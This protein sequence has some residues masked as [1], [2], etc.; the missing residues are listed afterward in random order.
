MTQNTKLRSRDHTVYFGTKPLPV[1][2]V[3]LFCFIFKSSDHK[4]MLEIYW[5]NPSSLLKYKKEYG[6]RYH[7]SSQITQRKPF[8]PY[9]WHFIIKTILGLRNKFKW[10]LA[11]QVFFPQHSIS[12]IKATKVESILIFQVILHCTVFKIN[13]IDMTKMTLTA[14]HAGGR[15]G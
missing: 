3:I 7:H 5:I 2:L 14:N 9:L 13:H 15:G 8:N 4:D 1:K 6:F 11:R 10:S 12:I